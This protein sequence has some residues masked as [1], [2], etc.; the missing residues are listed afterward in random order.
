VKTTAN[1]PAWQ[2][3][4]LTAG[5]SAELPPGKVT[6]G[7]Y[8]GVAYAWQAGPA[9]RFAVWVGAGQGLAAWRATFQAPPQLTEPASTSVC[10]RAAS[11]QEARFAAGPYAVGVD[12]DAAGQI[13]HEATDHPAITEIAVAFTAANGTPAL[14]TWRV[15]TDAR[16][17]H[18]PWLARFLA[19]LACK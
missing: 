1:D 10:G 5:V 7:D 18:E 9:G 2:R 11:R 3:V 4:E 6:H 12:H 14:A 15:D 19:A 16:A 13:V 17:R 8:Q